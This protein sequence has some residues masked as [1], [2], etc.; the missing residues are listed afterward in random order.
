MNMNWLN[1]LF[2]FNHEL[3]R[4]FNRHSD[5]LIQIVCISLPFGY[6][7]FGDFD[8]RRFRF[9]IEEFGE[10]QSCRSRHD[11]RRQQMG[12]VDAETDVGSQHG[13]FFIG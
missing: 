4:H 12:R 11:R 8:F 3:N 7:N 6:S 5:T 2:R 10:S 9:G 13:T 1:F